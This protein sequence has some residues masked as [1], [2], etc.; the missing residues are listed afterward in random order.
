MNLGDFREFEVDLR[1]RFAENARGGHKKRAP[2]CA[3]PPSC[4]PLN[5]RRP[6]VFIENDESGR[7]SRKYFKFV[8][9]RKWRGKPA[10]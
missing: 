8:K 6:V 3:P 7:F 2:F 10:K 5:S 4:L 9:K 1:R